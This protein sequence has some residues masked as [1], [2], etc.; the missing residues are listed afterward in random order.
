MLLVAH[1]RKAVPDTYFHGIQGTELHELNF[2]QEG[3]R[4]GARS[5]GLGIGGIQD[6]PK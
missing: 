4:N 3:K 1:L 2:G 6:L 5:D